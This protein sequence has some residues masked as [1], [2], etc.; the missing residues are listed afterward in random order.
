MQ[1][2]AADDL[3]LGTAPRLQPTAT[4]T[5]QAARALNLPV[6]LGASIALHA[7][8]LLAVGYLPPPSVYLSSLPT[9]MDFVVLESPP[10]PE[11]APPEPE[12][13]PEPEIAPPP[14]AA[15]PTPPPPRP[16]PRAAEPPP[17]APVLTAPE[18]APGPAEWAHPEGEEGG[19]LGGTPGG[20]GT[21]EA[22]A[23]AASE[24][25]PEP[26]PRFSRA[27]LRQRL[28]GYIRGPLSQHIAA[29]TSYP[30]VA[31]REHAEGVV[32]LRMRLDRTGRVLAV[33][34]SR[35]SGHPT[36]DEAALASVR[37]MQTVPA[38]PA[39]LPWDE[40]QEL[41]LPVTY[42]LQ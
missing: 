21:G 13:E 15:A 17:P 32:V 37:G 3:E 23:P 25:T 40:T 5:P 8:V 41:P 19:T 36:L 30:V 38:P 39:G 27:E 28:L 4:A 1:S 31:R 16:T 42:Q 6:V 18:S 34:L 24:A 35:S 10:E 9:E 33:R 29:H 11:P 22:V 7:A 20:T 2:S 26:R 14:P 12:P